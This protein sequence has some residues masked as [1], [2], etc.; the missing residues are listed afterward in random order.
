M[1][2][3]KFDRYLAEVQKIITMPIENVRRGDVDTLRGHMGA[4]VSDEIGITQMWLPPLIENV[5]SFINAY[6]ERADKVKEEWRRK[7]KE[8]ERDGMLPFLT[9]VMFDLMAEIVYHIIVE[10]RY[11]SYDSRRLKDFCYHKAVEFIVQHPYDED[12]MDK[13][14]EFAIDITRSD[15]FKDVMKG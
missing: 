8:V 6:N 4:I 13:V 3:A 12:Y 7:I 14:R 11:V 2:K 5:Q 9:E 10:L 1:F 15:E